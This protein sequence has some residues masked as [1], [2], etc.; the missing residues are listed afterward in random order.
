LHLYHLSD[1]QAAVVACV[2]RLAR[3]ALTD[4]GVPFTPRQLRD[5]AARAY[6]RITARVI[7]GNDGEPELVDWEDPSNVAVIAVET[8]KAY[9]VKH[10]LLDGP[11]LE[12]VTSALVVARRDGPGGYA[13]HL[14]VVRTSGRIEWPGAD[15]SAA[16]RERRVE[17][18]VVLTRN[19]FSA[20]P[21]YEANLRAERIRRAARV[22][23]PAVVLGLG[24]VAVAEGA[25]AVPLLHWL[26][27]LILWA[28]GLY[29]SYLLV[30]LEKTSTYANAL[31]ARVC[32][33]DTGDPTCKSVISSAGG[34]LL[35]FSFTD[36]GA[37]YFLTL[38]ATG[39][40]ALA[41]GRFPG[42]SGVFL[43][44]AVV[45]APVSLYLMY[46]QAFVLRRFCMLC[47]GV[48]T[49]LLAQLG[50]FIVARPFAGTALFDL[51]ALAVTAG[52]ALAVV[53]AYSLAYRAFEVT[54]R[55]W[56]HVIMKERSLADPAYY[57]LAAEREPEMEVGEAPGAIVLGN[58][59]SP[60]QLTA[61]L[62]LGCAACG[63]KLADLR[64]VADWL[65]HDMSVRILLRAETA[66]RQGNEE[67]VRWLLSG[68]QEAALEFLTHWYVAF[69]DESARGSH[70]SVPR[71]L[72]R[73]RAVV[74]AAPDSPEVA[75][76]LAAQEQA[77]R[78]VVQT[79]LLIL[80]GRRVPMTHWEASSLVEVLEQ[81]LPAAVA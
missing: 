13:A 66:T 77:L 63:G 55:A 52:V 14:G 31:L 15:A 44:A 50:Y 7:V 3:I 59:E 43:A 10:A 81:Q 20:E 69:T 47:V 17:E 25:R 12:P 57:R 58:A 56:P 72:D 9:H 16:G 27:L 19:R 79:P 24:A 23:A 42:F 62:S 33:A 34:K 35:G 41:V 29:L 75:G 73:A 11:V 30:M 64:R 76:I 53:A 4:L 65:E 5:L 46:Q 61:I 39:L 74:G 36:L 54:V 49:V 67:V 26:P 48:H 28:A 1:K 2:E 21:D 78:D 18:F 70:V 60:V 38:A 32:R 80:D 22:L 6:L 68:V 37:V 45:P 71:V 40:L 51:P 8:L